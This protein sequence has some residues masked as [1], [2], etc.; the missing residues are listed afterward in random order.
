MM[1]ASDV[2]TLGQK[3][4]LFSRCVAMLLLEIERQGYE[5]AIAWAYRPPE[6]SILYAARKLGIPN[7]NHGKKLAIDLDLFKD[8]IYLARTEDHRLFGEFWE[9]L[10][11][12]CRWGGRFQDGNHYS[13]AHE[14]VQ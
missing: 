2:V 14:G 13:L 11:P 3:Q 10:H 4:R 8:G 1:S 12:L 7:S 5:C 9:R 6:A